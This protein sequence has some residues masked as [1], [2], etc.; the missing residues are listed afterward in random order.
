MLILQLKQMYVLCSFIAVLIWNLVSFTCDS[1]IFFLKI[2]SFLFSISADYS[3]NLHLCDWQIYGDP[4]AADIVF[5]SG[6]NI[7]VVGIN[8]TTQ[9]KLTG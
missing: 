1:F 9:V 2:L 5:T 7:D 4:E 6:A 8:I 3:L